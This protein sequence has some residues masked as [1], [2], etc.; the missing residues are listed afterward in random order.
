MVP[1]TGWLVF[2][3]AVVVMLAFDL[4]VLNR[5]AH[6][7][8]FREA[9]L[10][11]IGW[12]SLACL[13][14]C[15]VFLSRGPDTG[16]QF[17]TGYLVELSLSVDNVFLF[18][19]I[20]SQFGV[21]KQYQHRV[22]FWGIVGAVVMRGI[23]IVAGTALLAKFHWIMYV[24]GVFLM[25]TG[26]RL[27][28]HRHREVDVADMLIV[29]WLQK[30]VRLIPDYDGQR[31]LTVRD[32]LR[33]ATPLLLVLVVI[34]V[35]DLMFALD[36]IPAVLAISRDPFIVFT[37]NIFAILGLRSFYFLL[38][39]VIGMFEFLSVGLSLVL[40]YVGF[41]MLGFAEIPTGV[42]LAVIAALIGVSILISLW[43]NRAPSQQPSADQEP[44]NKVKTLS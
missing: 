11:S 40:I 20:F 42:S 7:P 44:A 24:F 8:S 21:A 10:Y 12:V 23:M 43:K 19:V 30:H 36:S 33:Y 15:Y 17:V 31:F 41:K 22:L 29:Q 37:S 1:Y 6:E 16:L 35:T 5:R 26:I 13:F 25:L 32:G 28:L 18:A 27:F 34:E 38:A 14:A 3:I 39:G 9:L 4:G 2:G